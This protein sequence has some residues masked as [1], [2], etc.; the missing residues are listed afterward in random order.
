MR[1][2]LRPRP[3]RA[4]CSS[5]DR[6][7]AATSAGGRW[8]NTGCAF[9][10]PPSAPTRRPMASGAEC[11]LVTLKADVRSVLPTSS[12]GDRRRV[13][14]SPLRGTSCD[15]VLTCACA[16]RPGLVP[17]ETMSVRGSY[18][19]EQL[20]PGVWRIAASLPATTSLPP[21]SSGRSTWPP[22]SRGGGYESGP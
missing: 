1:T 18:Q 6:G 22:P 20:E 17:Y 7:I 19:N 10:F 15:S 14:D 3:S 11:P 2:I 16:G 21:I 9:E 12:D 8:G 5:L 4:T 13:F